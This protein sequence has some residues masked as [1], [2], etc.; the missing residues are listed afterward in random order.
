MAS[1]IYHGT[2]TTTSYERLKECMIDISMLVSPKLDP[3]KLWFHFK[4]GLRIFAAE[5][6]KYVVR[7]QRTENEDIF[8]NPNY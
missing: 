4:Y 1:R 5:Q 6:L 7:I 3:F 2:L 8:Y